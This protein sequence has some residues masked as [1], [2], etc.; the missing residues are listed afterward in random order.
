LSSPTSPDQSKTNVV[1]RRQFFSWQQVES[2]DY[3]S[4]VANLRDIGCPEQT[5]RDIIIA[6]VNAVYAR[7]RATDVM[8]S[9]QQWWRAEPDT[10]GTQAAAARLRELD[11]ERRTLLTQLLGPNWETGDQISL[12]RPSR[13]GLNLDGAVLGALPNDVK[14]SVQ[15]IS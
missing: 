12:P 10:N 14:Q 1:V 8:I 4:Y 9:D 6:D 3:P 15:E 11:E 5:I 2:D 13:P 7:K